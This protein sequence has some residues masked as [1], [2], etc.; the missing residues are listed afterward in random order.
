M[1]TVQRLTL[2]AAGLAVL[3]S[4]GCGGGTESASATTPNSPAPARTNEVTSNVTENATAG[5]PASVGAVNPAASTESAPVTNASATV[6]EPEAI[7]VLRQI[8]QLRARPIEGDLEASREARRARNLQI[9][10]LAT[11][12]LRLTMNDPEQTAAF[13]QGINQLLEAR[14]Q[15][16]LSGSA[17]DVELL[18]SD[19]Q[20]I[21]DRDPKSASAAEGIYHLARF[22]H[23]KAGLVGK[24][25]PVWFETLSRWARE[26]AERFPEQSQR[27]VSLLFGA[28][29]S[30]ELHALGTEDT[31]L[32]Q[33]LSTEAKLCYTALAEHFPDTD[34]GQEATAVLRRMAVVGQTLSQFSG[35]TVD[36]G[37]VTAD[38]FAGKP[39]LIYFW[40]SHSKDFRDD[41]LPL[42]IAIREQVPADRLRMVGVPLDEE[43]QEFEAFVEA[44]AVPGQ[45]I[46]FTESGQRSWDSPL[47][48][49]WGI[50]RV[51]SIWLVDSNR[52]VVTTEASAITL[53]DELRAL[54]AR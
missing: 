18:Y 34:Q 45:Q 4:A 40:D 35:P 52:T 21:N 23:T 47:L 49:F 15:L 5:I 22:A 37:F 17:E 20:A 13:Q 33:R 19:V 6:E 51:P 12:V 11:N 8:Q 16:A 9:V 25:N 38:D 28:A 44:Q 27:A 53:N 14:F 2:T 1:N 32:K 42:L 26:F 43:E 31:T 46:F 39:T 54:L 7:A 36:G 41:L 3:T 48:R 30:C 50:S 29:R 24:S 10:D